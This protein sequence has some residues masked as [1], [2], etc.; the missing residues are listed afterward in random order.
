M[1]RFNSTRANSKFRTVCV[2]AG[3]T[4]DQVYAVL[5]LTSEVAFLSLYIATFYRLLL[6]RNHIDVDAVQMYIKVCS[7]VVN[8]TLGSD[9]T[10]L[11]L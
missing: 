2:G 1:S 11:K 3:L 5:E 8:E 10:I 6:T 9:M 7:D 4:W